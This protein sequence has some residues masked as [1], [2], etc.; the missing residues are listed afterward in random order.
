M[1]VSAPRSR[2]SL[3][4]SIKVQ[5][6]VIRTLMIRQGQADHSQETL[7]FFWGIFEPMILT[8][9][10]VLLWS[11]TN[12]EG[13][14]P[15][16]NVFGLAIT[17]YSH[18]QLWRLGV[19]TSLHMVTTETWAYYH[20]NISVI[21]LVL[22]NVFMKSI[23][24]FTSF[25]IL[26]TV[27]VLFGLIDP[28]S[29]P[30]LVLAGWALDTLFVGSFALLMAGLAGLSEYIAKVLHPVMYIT[31]PIT[32]AFTLTDWLPPSFKVILEWSP[33]ANCCEMFR[34]GVFSASVKTYWSVP[35]IV[36]T[37]LI[38]LAIGLPILDYA[39]RHAE[40]H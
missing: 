21:D 31:L 22:S 25:V 40:P 34:A 27:C 1:S 18:I 4:D 26:A 5:L 35:L 19:L 10:V 14:H 37:S 28:I 17:A 20:R 9:G 15:G 3:I 6:R 16:V 30:G 36:L 13:Q 24:V 23:S 2:P 8:C 39:R 32:G 38:L 33:L 29:D 12:R 7:G 11:L